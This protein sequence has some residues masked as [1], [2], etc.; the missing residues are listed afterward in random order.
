MTDFSPVS[1][2]NNVP[3][4]RDASLG[5]L[6]ADK[7]FGNTGFFLFEQ[8]CFSDKIGR[9][10][11]F[12]ADMLAASYDP[13][14]IY[15]QVEFEGGGKYMFDFTDCEYKELK[16]GMNVS[17]TFRRKYYDAKRD[18]SGYFWKALPVKE[19]K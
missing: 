17:M 10:A 4:A 14:A 13:P 7:F 1:I 6:K 12:T 19:V 9:I 18:I 8:Y 15:G 11:S 16:T 3:L 2:G 5:Q